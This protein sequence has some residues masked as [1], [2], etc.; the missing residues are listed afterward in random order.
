MR[1]VATG[2]ERPKAASGGEGDHAELG[3]GGQQGVLGHDPDRVA[4]PAGVVQLD[5]AVEAVPAPGVGLGQL[6]GLHRGVGE[7]VLADQAAVDELRR[8]RDVRDG[9]VAVDMAIAAGLVELPAMTAYVAA[10]PA[11][12]GVP[13][14]REVLPLVD[15]DSR[16][17]M[18]S[19]MRLVWLLDAALPP[20]LC[21]KP[22]F[23]LAGNLLG[24]PDLLDEDAGVV[25]EYQ[26]ADHK[27]GARHRR[28]VRRED[29]FRDHGLEYFEVVGGDL[30]DRD[31]VVRRMLGARSRARWLPAGQRRWTLEAPLWWRW[32]EE[33][34]A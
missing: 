29:R 20:P 25:G 24:Y 5:G 12:T 32:A 16:S 30:H 9:V 8:T 18:E 28:D 3:R 27:E 19:R 6:Q 11:W 10:R 34:G 33:E 17:P 21:N 23:D 4:E 31:L 22:V 7:L 15:G 26:G 13:L 1:P 14:A 2:P